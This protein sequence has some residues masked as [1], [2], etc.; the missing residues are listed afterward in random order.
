MANPL[1]H[2]VTPVMAASE[3]ARRMAQE[4]NASGVLPTML[5]RMFEFSPIAIAITSSDGES[6][7]YLKVNQAYLD[8]IG[9]RWEDICDTPLSKAAAI[10]D[11]GFRRR[12]LKLDRDGGYV[13][14]P[15]EIRHSS[16]SRLSTLISA[17]RTVVDGIAYDLEIIVDVSEH[18]RQQAEQQAALHKAARTDVLS[19]LSNRRAFDELLHERLPTADQHPP[20]LALID[21]DGFK[22]INDTH[23]HAAGDAVIRALGQR[24]VASFRDDAFIARTGGDEF[25]LVIDDHGRADPQ[26]LRQRIAASF[27][28]VAF[29]DLA[30]ACTGSVGIARYQP[31]EGMDAFI[32]RAD[33]CMY[34]HKQQARTSEAALE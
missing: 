33:A 4:S 6:A 17:Q 31:G 29:G 16:G 9:K 3:A 24:L 13:G 7:R 27:T 12:C 34:A 5:L 28:P 20:T 22:Q 30:I 23:G 19:G 14:E 18:I 10:V 8:M 26:A 11:E 15:V 25:V 32:A 1:E 2:E 21:L